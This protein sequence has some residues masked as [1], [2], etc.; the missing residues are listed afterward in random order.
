MRWRD[1]DNLALLPDNFFQTPRRVH[2]IGIGGIGMSALALLLKARGHEVSGSDAC[3]SAMLTKLQTAGIKTIVGHYAG[4]LVTEGAPVEAVFFSSAVTE[5]NAERAAAVAQGIPQWHRAQLLAYFVNN[6]AY[7]IAVSG[8]HGKSTTSAMI[9]HILTQLGRNPTAILGAIYP[10]FDSNLRVGDPGLVVV[11]ADE[12]DGSFTL[13]KPTVSVVLNVEAEHLENYEDSEA[14]L[15]RAFEMFMDQTRQIAVLNLEDVEMWERLSARRREDLIV[16]NYRT[17]LGGNL[18][19]SAIESRA[20]KTHYDLFYNRDWVGTFNLGVPGR[21]NVSNGLA[22][23]S[24]AC[25]QFQL[26]PEA[27]VHSVT[28]AATALQDFHGVARRFQLCGEANQVVVYD[29]YAHHPTE[30]GSTLQMAHEFLG[31]PLVVIFQPHRYSR[32]QQLGQEFGPSFAAADRIIITQLY[33]AFETPIEGVSGRIV[34]DAVRQSFPDKPIY[35][36]ETLEEARRLAGD[37]AR[38]GDA[39]ITMG[40]GDISR[41][42]ALLLQDLQHAQ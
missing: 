21:H 27:F 35:Y 33:S 20:G 15:W 11:E 31:R 13:L 12:S 28:S 4:Y 39:M 30:V 7:S 22:A 6:A 2:F 16:A 32:T 19:A 3:A 37:L 23:M 41:L 14:E 29:D 1:F 42:P 26:A 10:P 5:D 40:A 8:T 38:P 34:F 25:I 18:A 24:A 9:A 36:V 17:G